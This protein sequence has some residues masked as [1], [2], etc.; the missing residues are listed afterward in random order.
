MNY[1]STRGG[2]L[3][4]SGAE[5]IRSGI[6]VDGGLFVPLNL[7]GFPVPTGTV[8]GYVGLAAAVLAAVLSDYT[9]EELQQCSAAAYAVDKVDD[10]DTVPVTPVGN[11][12]VLELWHGPTSAFKDMA[13]QI[14][15]HLMSLALKKT[16]ESSD[17][18][19]L[20]ATSGDT[21]KAALEG[22]RDVPRT[23]ILV[24]YPSEGVSEVQRAQ[25][26]TQDGKNVG[27]VAVE[28]NFDDAQTGVKKIFSSVQMREVLAKKNLKLSSANSI[29]WG[30]LAPQI[31]YYYSAYRSL[32]E[33]G[34]IRYGEP[35][36]FVVPTGN[37]GNILAGYYAKQMGLPIHRLICASNDNNVLTDFLRTGVYDRNRPFHQTI[38]PSMDILIS[39]NLE[40][41]LYHATDG[42]TGKVSSWME[43]LNA[44]GRYAVDTQTLTKIQ[45]TFWA[46][47]AATEESMAT[48][49]QVWQQHGYLLDPHTAV[50]W[51]VAEVYEAQTQDAT[52]TIVLS[53]ASPFKFADT[54]LQ[55]LLPDQPVLADD[56]LALLTR[57]SELTGWPIPA[58]LAGLAKKEV[59]HRQKCRVDTMPEV[60]AY[61]V[62]N[63]LEPKAN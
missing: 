61:F 56:S 41:L 17:M 47:W 49:R 54:V 35:I 55:A 48:I 11:R 24:F 32:C 45:A 18:L 3:T 36:N 6:A 43:Q 27:V 12:H 26:V 20:V 63:R 14:M 2:G 4:V 10:P 1:K 50:A 9:P 34:K 40:R 62:E 33:T 7:P 52:P 44:T 22:F 19:I 39:S 60:V 58:G 25:M 15:P 8:S 51:K 38:S 30:R 28:G 21:G 46:D 31:A 59:K 16:A 23:Q 29:N 57:L 13:L 42:D 53:T 5:A 37:F